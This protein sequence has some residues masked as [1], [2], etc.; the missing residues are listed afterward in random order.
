MDFCS[1]SKAR[2]SIWR[3]R[4]RLTPYCAGQIF[5]GGRLVLQAPLGQDVALAVGQLGHGL[6]EQAHAEGLLLALGERGLLAAA[7]SSASQ[8]CHSL[9]PS[10]RSGAFSEASPPDR[11]RFMR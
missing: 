5:Q 6:L 1:F 11:R 8:S 3:T 4:S 9:S 7:V 2:T 10:E